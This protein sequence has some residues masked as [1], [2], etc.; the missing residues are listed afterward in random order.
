MCKYTLPKILPERGDRQKHQRRPIDESSLVDEDSVDWRKGMA[1]KLAEARI[2]YP[3]PVFIA[4]TS[5]L[6]RPGSTP[7]TLGQDRYGKKGFWH[8]QSIVD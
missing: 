1:E 2:E 5:S 8:S 6:Y 4:A 3:L 7:L